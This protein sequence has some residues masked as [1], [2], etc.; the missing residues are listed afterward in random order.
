SIYR[1]VAEGRLAQAEALVRIKALKRQMSDAA[2]GVLLATP[3]WGAAPATSAP[4]QLVD[5]IFVWGLDPA[6]AASL[7]AT[8]EHARIEAFAPS[9]NVTTADGIF[10]DAALQGLAAIQSMLAATRS[11]RALVIVADTGIADEAVA[12]GFDAMFRTAMEE[13]PALVARVIRVP[14]DIG[15][16]ELRQLVHE[17][18]CTDA[19]RGAAVRHV[20]DAGGLRREVSRWRVL[21]QHLQGQAQSAAPVA[22][23][24]GG[25]Y[26]ITGGAGGIGLQF[27]RE[28]LAQCRS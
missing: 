11:V 20:R 28:I 17:E 19:P 1:A 26:L 24:E 15:A 23:K 27:A 14:A 16:A 18:S 9:E 21:G 13:T 7:K 10:T 6:V 25:C 3:E 12:C 8:H 22:F 4:A 5:K 2:Q